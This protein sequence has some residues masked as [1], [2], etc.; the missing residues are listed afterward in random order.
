M[1]TLTTPQ[2]ASAAAIN[3]FAPVSNYLLFA[4]L[5]WDWGWILDM[6][7]WNF[8]DRAAYLF[9]LVVSYFIAAMVC[10]A[11]AEIIKQSK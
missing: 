2:K 4:Y 5:H 3:I 10:A 11:A 8:A 6:G 9:G 1:K 7:L